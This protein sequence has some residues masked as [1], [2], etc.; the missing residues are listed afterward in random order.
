MK[1]TMKANLLY[2][3]EHLTCGKYLKEIDTGFFFRNLKKDQPGNW[4]GRL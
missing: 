4:N 2:V 1:Q 3:N